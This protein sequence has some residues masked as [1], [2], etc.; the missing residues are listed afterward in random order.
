M[1]LD[2]DK[3]LIEKY[4]SSSQKIRVSTE[5]W[6]NKQSYCPNCGRQQLQK[7][8]NNCPVADFFCKGCNEDFELKSKKNDIGNRIVDGAYQTMMNKLTSD[9][10]PNLFLLSYDVSYFRVLN[11]FVIPKHFFYPLCD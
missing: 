5:N 9:Q 2:L 11:F 1:D 6:V 8:S 10:S 3:S 4:T 7:Y